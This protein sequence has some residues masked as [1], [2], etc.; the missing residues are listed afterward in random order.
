ML[1]CASA[2]KLY[3]TFKSPICLILKSLVNNTEKQ[4]YVFANKILI[5]LTL[6]CIKRIEIIKSQIKTNNVDY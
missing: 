6:D 3:F 1:N 2:K 5:D 4:L